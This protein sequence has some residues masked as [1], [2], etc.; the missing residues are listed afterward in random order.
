MKKTLTL[1]IGILCLN[2]LSGQVGINTSTPKATLDVMANNN[3]SPIGVLPPR[4]SGDQLKSLDSYYTDD[5]K[6]AI[7]YVTGPVSS[8]SQKTQNISA[9]GY[10]YYD[11][12]LSVWTSIGSSSEPW[13]NS[14]G[15][16]AVLNTEAI[17]HMGPISL[18]S[19]SSDPNAALDITSGSKGILIPRISKSERDAILT[20]L[21]NGLLIY[22]TTNN[23]LNYFDGNANKWLSL[24]GT[25]EPATFGL[26]NCNTPSGP[27]GT[28]KQGTALNSDSNTYTLKVNVTSTGNYQV[29]VNTGNGYSFNKSGIFTETGTFDIVLAGQGTPVNGP[30]DNTPVLIFNGVNVN[31]ACTLPLIHVNGATTSF[32]VNCSGST[33]NGIYRQGI[34]L[35]ATN[36]I[37]IPVSGVITPGNA[38]VETAVINGIKFS[39]GTVSI[40]NSTTSIR[41]YGQGTPASISASTLYT[42]TVPGSSSC[43]FSI[44]VITSVGTF[45][46]PAD[47][48][49]QILQANSAATDGEYFIKGLGGTPVKTYCDMTNGGYTLI[50]SYSEKAAFTDDTAFLVN[51]S[52]NLNVNDNRNYS[53]ATGVSGTIVYKNY[54]L[55]LAVRQNIR[56]NISKNQYR[57]RIVN[58]VANV[59]NNTDS[60]ANNNFAVIDFNIPTSG[61]YDM[62]G[63]M[64]TD[65]P[66]VKVSGK[67]FGKN[68]SMDGTGSGNYVSFDGQVWNYARMYNA[69]Y[70]KVI[71]HQSTPPNYP[72]SYTSSNGTVIN[73]NL[74]ALDDIWGLYSDSTFNHHIGKCG[75]TASDDYAGVVECNGTGRVPHSFNSGEGR[76]IQWFVK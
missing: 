29:I 1:S 47:R 3:N 22:N 39:S 60:W 72:F 43:S 67:I 53:S 56:S 65:F 9:P 71:S 18:G 68:Y 31:P 45:A 19:S 36:Y 30:V 13:K 4:L 14:S 75:N 38:V 10:Y 52:Q 15:Q 35:D 59:S 2:L 55:P 46:N 7:V 6:G 37:D 42:F 57:V 32:T 8:P 28:Y 24:C 25:Y 23:C 12:D 70:A 54:L 11:S 69:Q 62:I 76:Y 16:G 33:I 27:N 66:Y 63:G 64:F 5:Q 17:Y 26:L 40:D 34:A 49:Y 21:A 20:P 48:C 61:A 44:N 58:N 74:T 50:Q 73:T 41:L 51:N